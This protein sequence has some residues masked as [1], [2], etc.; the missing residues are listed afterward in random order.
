MM[1]L[2]NRKSKRLTFENTSLLIALVGLIIP[3][4]AYFILG[5]HLYPPIILM[6]IFSYITC[7]NTYKNKTNSA[8]PIL[9]G[10]RIVSQEHVT[11][12]KKT[13][14]FKM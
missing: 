7:S 10:Q 9:T 3:K 2:L 12:T 14:P 8:C 6:E 11:V 1:F 5:R 13:D 4:I